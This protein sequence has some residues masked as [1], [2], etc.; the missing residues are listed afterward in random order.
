MSSVSKAIKSLTQVI[1]KEEVPTMEE[2]SDI[3]V[4][5]SKLSIL[6][7][8]DGQSS[9][10]DVSSIDCSDESSGEESCSEDSCDTESS[11]RS[12]KKGPRSKGYT[13]YI[14]N[15]GSRAK[16]SDKSDKYK[17]NYYNRHCEN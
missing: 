4:I 11:K 5:V 17:D 13:L 3:L 15:G 16:W 9:G 2:M 1:K 10:E 7:K 6:M 8:E 12:Y 14:E